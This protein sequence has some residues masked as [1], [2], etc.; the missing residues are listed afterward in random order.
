MKAYALVTR[1]NQF[2]ALDEAATP[3]D[4]NYTLVE[5]LDKW[6]VC[7]RHKKRL[8]L[9]AAV[10]LNSDDYD[11]CDDDAGENSHDFAVETVRH[12]LQHGHD[13]GEFNRCPYPEDWAWTW[14]VVSVTRWR[15]LLRV[16]THTYWD[17]EDYAI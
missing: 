9:I 4:L 2:H 14:P 12:E 3:E 10:N 17:A 16:G 7:V 8:C 11:E 15:T 13:Y 5:E 1:K 6:G